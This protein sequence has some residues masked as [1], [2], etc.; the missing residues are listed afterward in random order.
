MVPGV[1]AEYADSRIGSP[2]YS[3]AGSAAEIR[4]FREFR[5]PDCGRVGEGMVENGP[6]GEPMAALENL[7][8]TLGFSNSSAATAQGD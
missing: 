5:D 3:E 8:R 6:R 4:Y 1:A 7:C 2:A